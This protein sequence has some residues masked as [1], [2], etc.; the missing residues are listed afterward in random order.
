MSTAATA[1]SAPSKGLHIAL[2]IVQV[3]LGLAFLMAGSG[4]ATQPIADLAVRMPWAAHVPEAL[5]RFIGTSEILGGLGLI[6]PAA[7]RIMP[8][9][10]G[11]AG[12]GLVTVMVLASAFHLSR[13]EAMALPVNFV[14]GGLAAFVAW[15]RLKKAP[16]APRGA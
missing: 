12:I 7:T 1:S 10:T 16:I 8:K 6:L 15:G 11:F 9:L 3:L 13:G 5:V 2:W 4:K 14:L